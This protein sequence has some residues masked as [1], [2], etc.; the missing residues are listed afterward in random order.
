MGQKWDAAGNNEVFLNVVHTCYIMLDKSV[1]NVNDDSI[2]NT[3][4]V[5]DVYMSGGKCVCF[6]LIYSECKKVYMHLG[7]WF[8]STTL[9]QSRFNVG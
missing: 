6:K 8:C 4:Y 7:N 2:R 3:T 1:T 5:F 9:N